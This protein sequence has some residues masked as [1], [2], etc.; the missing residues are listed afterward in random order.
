MI[1]SIVFFVVAIVAVGF[2]VS[3]GWS[4]SKAKKEAKNY[5]AKL[6]EAEQKE[7]QTRKQLEEKEDYI[8]VWDG[9]YQQLAKQG[10]SQNQ[11]AA[12]NPEP[13]SDPAVAGYDSPYK[14][15]HPDLRVSPEEPTTPATNEKVVHLT[16]DDG[17]SQYTGQV[18]EALDVYGMKATFFV[19]YT[20]KPEL[21]SY[22]QEIVN[23]GHTLAI[24]TASH[25]YK[26]I[27][28]SVENYLE[29]FYKVYQLVSEKTG[30][31]P[32]IFRFPGGSTSLNSHAA[33]PEIAKEMES[34]GFVYFDWNV[35]CGDGSNRAT[36][37]S[38][39]QSI[40]DGVSKHQDSVVLMHDTRVPTVTILPE[41]L[42]QL[43]E[44]GCKFEPLNQDSR[45]VQFYNK[46][47]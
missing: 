10:E 12:N 11:G 16:F 4:S 22:Y 25:E 26:T 43:V 21:Q 17:P 13:V 37:E 19:T 32:T 44:M 28:A 18:L 39:L 33:G 34:R 47:Y 3:L 2:A 38:V 8:E 14:D 5:Q 6:K 9:V 41:V 7:Q 1:A 31:K 46:K 27:Y 40:I 42:K 23:R 29:D 36:Q 15:I 30:V 45:Q 24:H 20:D 35:S